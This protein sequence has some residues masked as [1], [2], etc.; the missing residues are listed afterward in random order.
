MPQLHFCSESNDLLVPRCARPR[1]CAASAPVRRG[2]QGRRGLLRSR[3]LAEKTS[4]RSGALTPPRA[5]SSRRCPCGC[6]AAAAGWGDRLEYV[7][8][9]CGYREAAT[10]SCIYR[11]VVHHSQEEKTIVKSDV[12]SD[13]ALP[14]TREQTCPRCESNE[15]VYFS[16]ATSEGMN[17]FY[18]CMACSHRWQDNV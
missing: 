5:P 18:Q 9:T 11:N 14:R 8:K 15:A 17:V 2:A 10:D 16:T 4:S 3:R 7:C 6:E 12:R 13:P 1:A